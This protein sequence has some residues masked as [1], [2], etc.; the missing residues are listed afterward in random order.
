MRAILI[1]LLLAPLLGAAQAQLT[2]PSATL[3][4]IPPDASGFEYRTLLKE[5]RL[6]AVADTLADV[7]AAGERNL[8]W[9]EAINE[10]RPVGEK[11]SLTS[12]EATRAF[13]PESP[14]VYNPK[15]ILTNFAAA[16]EGMPEEMRQ[17]LFTGAAFP[18]ELNIPAEI[19]I[20]E[21]RKLDRVY[22]S[23]ARWRTLSRFIGRLTKNR[24][25]DIRGYHF[26][27]RLPYREA[28]LASPGALSGEE[29]AQI[30]D[31][32]IGMCFNDFWSSMSYC[33]RTVTN[34]VAAGQ[35]LN[36]LYNK[37]RGKSASLYA[38][39]F[40]IPSS[41]PRP[42]F[43][44]EKLNGG[45]EQFLAPFT[46]PQAEDVRR[47]LQDNIE[48]EWKVGEWS[49]KLPF[50]NANNHASVV[51]LPDVTPQVN[52]LGGNRI[53]MNSRQPLTEYD[54]QHTIRHEFGHVLGFPDCYVEF[55]D[56]D[57][58]AM[59][60]YQVDTGNI[61]CSRRGKVGPQHVEELRRAY[62]P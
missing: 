52:G 31:W 35:D 8:A 5:Q 28:K 34:A 33:R 44:F 13:P 22:Q 12:P 56:E 45:A 42:E 16:R 32:L 27:S 26:L 6:S 2:P 50:T 59:V 9:L 4:D 46:D 18:A 17:V 24:V 19:Y 58:G 49:L 39:L 38:E 41:A 1:S 25:N 14:S 48:A 53:T 55:F 7:M 36:P 54:A 3:P 20:E 60:N 47:F 57:L 29:K 61:M 10:A 23:A 21:A 62:R 51:F 30:R 43:R 15:I 37:W 40:A 11:L